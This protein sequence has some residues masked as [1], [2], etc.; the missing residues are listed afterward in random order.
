MSKQNRNVH[1]N[2]KPICYS[3]QTSEYGVEQNLTILG[4]Y[5]HI[6][7]FAYTKINYPESYGLYKALRYLYI[8]TINYYKILN[9][10]CLISIPTRLTVC[11]SLNFM[12]NKP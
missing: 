12:P 3:V 7:A 6:Q 4:Y 10:L 8:L 11:I 2:N 5:S 9:I 1:N